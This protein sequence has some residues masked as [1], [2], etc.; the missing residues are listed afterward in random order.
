MKKTIAIL[1]ILFVMCCTGLVEAAVPVTVYKLPGDSWPAGEEDF[2]NPNGPWAV[3]LQEPAAGFTDSYSLAPSVFWPIQGEAG[4]Y[5]WGTGYVAIQSY[6]GQAAAITYADSGFVII[7]FTVP[8]SWTGSTATTS[9][10]TSTPTSI[11]WN[12]VEIYKLNA[13][14]TVA[15][16]LLDVSMLNDP[17]VDHEIDFSFQVAIVPGD[18]IMYRTSSRYGAAFNYLDNYTILDTGSVNIPADND[19]YVS[20]AN[21]TV[22]YGSADNLVVAYDSEPNNLLH[23]SVFLQ[24]STLASELS[25][26]IASDIFDAKLWVYQKERKSCSGSIYYANAAWNESTIT[27]VNKPSFTDTGDNFNLTNEQGWCSIDITNEVKAWLAGTKTNYGLVFQAESTFLGGVQGWHSSE[28]IDPEQSPFLLGSNVKPFIQVRFSPESCSEA[29][30]LGYGVSA[31]L[32]KDCKVNLD[33][34]AGFVGKWLNCNN[35]VNPDCY[36]SWN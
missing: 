28:C 20:E 25:G 1:A 8:A 23:S 11:A 3:K 24:A 10:T 5:Y 14:G 12:D 35:P 36:L 19:A 21:S 34:L 33:D 29:Q 13:A 31:D 22:N 2:N 26:H 6:Q 18:R 9:G 4:Y 7:E 15:K 16:V 30:T 32:N 17:A 27:W